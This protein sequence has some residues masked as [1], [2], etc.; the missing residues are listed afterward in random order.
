M[1]SYLSEVWQFI[2]S[3]YHLTIA[4]WSTVPQAIAFG[5][6]AYALW[7]V[8]RDL[9]RITAF[10]LGRTTEPPVIQPLPPGVRWRGIGGAVA[11]WWMASARR[12][13]ALL[14]MMAAS[15]QQAADAAKAVADLRREL[16]PSITMP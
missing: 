14:T 10:L 4:D 11:R 7:Q 12:E 5:G 13:A 6:L 16:K 3:A 15:N 1:L 8:G 2:A 9:T